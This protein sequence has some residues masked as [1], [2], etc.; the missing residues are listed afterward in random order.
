MAPNHLTRRTVVVSASTGLLA[1]TA[2]VFYGSHS[3]SALDVS[4][5]DFEIAEQTK[6]S[7]TAPEL[8]PL[9]IT[10]EYV[11]ESNVAPDHLKIIPRVQ[12]KSSPHGWHE[13]DAVEFE[14]GEQSI[15]GE[16]AV[17]LELMELMALRDVFPQAEGEEETRQ[18]RAELLA[19]VYDGESQIGTAEAKASFPLVLRH[20]EAQAMVGLEATGELG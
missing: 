19:A 9:E 12:V 11:V 4:V 15:T 5:Q 8:L 16:F 7:A 10:G 14:L 1:A 13:Y 6:S 3:A 2:G 20:E 18:L 17:T